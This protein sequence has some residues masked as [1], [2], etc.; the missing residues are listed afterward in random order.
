MNGERF[1]VLESFP[2]KEYTRLKLKSMDSRSSK[3]VS[4][5]V[6]SEMW[7]SEQRLEKNLGDRHLHDFVFGY[8]LTCHRVQGS[9]MKKVLFVD[10][11]VSFFLDQ[12]AFRYTG[13]TRASEH[14]TVAL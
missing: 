11:D 13:V 9:T 4:V 6:D 3:V 1:K 2:D 12:E 14:V 10:E 5:R 8:A 7:T